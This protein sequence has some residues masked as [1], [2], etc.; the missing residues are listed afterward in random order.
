MKV[1]PDKSGKY[2][3]R[4][5][6]EQAELDNEC[7]DLITSFLLKRNGEVKFPISTDDLTVLIEGK[8]ADFD[9]QADL[10]G[11]G[12]NIEGVTIFKPGTKPVVRISEELWEPNRENRLRTTMMHEL[13]HVHFHR[14]L[15]ENILD[16][17]TRQSSF[18]DRKDRK[19]DLI[20]RCNRDTILTAT[21]IDWVEWQAGYSSGAFLVPITPLKRLV[22]DNLKAQNRL[23]TAAESSESGKELVR[24]VQSVF[25]VSEQAAR[26]RL[27]KLKFLTEQET[28]IPLI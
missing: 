27:L 18:I 9:Q 26:V 3:V 17:E 1:L 2:P 28:P 22:Q 13:G 6:Y 15:F 16:G 4:V 12:L 14:V 10:S 7:E 19:M 20:I 5:F 23:A 21:A 25:Q 8:T 11:E 24:Q